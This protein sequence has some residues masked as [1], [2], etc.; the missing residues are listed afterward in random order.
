MELLSGGALLDRILDMPNRQFS[1]HHA[2]DIM[3]QVRNHRLLMGE[4]GY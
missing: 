4:N 2:L 1:E 3:K